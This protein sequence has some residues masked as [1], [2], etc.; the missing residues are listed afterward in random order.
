MIKMHGR[1][2]GDNIEL[3]TISDPAL[4]RVEI[5]SGQIDQI[6][7]NMVVNA[8]D[9]MPQGGKLTIETANEELDD[10]YFRDRGV[11]SVGK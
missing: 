8:R 10:T 11:E 1:L 4:W 2:I 6:I 3:L 9:T 7:I 5:D